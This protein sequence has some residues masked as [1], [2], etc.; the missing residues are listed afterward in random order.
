MAALANITATAPTEQE[1]PEAR[2][3]RLA[4]ELADALNWWNG[5]FWS[6]HVYPSEAMPRGPFGFSQDVE[7]PYRS[8]N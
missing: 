4:H 1:S 6:A 7:P 3:H 8:V 2:V 5:G